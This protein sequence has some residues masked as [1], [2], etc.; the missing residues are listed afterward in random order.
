MT[1]IQ[2]DFPMRGPFG[3]DMSAAFKELAEDIAKEE[4]LI[5]KIW[6]ENATTKEAGGIYLFADEAN[7][8]R[9]LKKHT[10]RL[11]KFGMQG[12]ASKLFDVNV[13]LS[14]IDKAPLN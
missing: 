9:Y 14:L 2:I 3:G 6:T 13:P 11:E 4:G 7:A 12:I 8:R 10:E 1:L 5:W